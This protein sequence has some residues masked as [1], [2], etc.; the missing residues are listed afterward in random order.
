MTV[1]TRLALL[2]I[3]EDSVEEKDRLR[4]T[5][6]AVLNILEDLDLE[7]AK[8]EDANT[9]L[10]AE[11]AERSRAEQALQSRTDDLA[12]SNADLEQ[13]AYVASHD[14]SEPLRAISGPISLLARRYQGQLD[15]EADEY[16]GFVVDGCQRMQAIIDGLLAYSRVGRFEADG[17]V[18]R[19]QHVA[20]RRSLAWLAPT[21]DATD[22]E[23]SVGELPMVFAEKTQL[24]EVFLNLISN[25]LKFVAPD[26]SLAS[27]SG[28]TSRRARGVSV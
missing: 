23:V 16:I 17:G 19:L 10:R 12:N 13:F 14:L 25:A 21:I 1:T 22:A 2:N 7:K 15:A 9:E 28:R 20:R 8:I 6:R 4:D 11:V 3:L 27:P 26:G 24:S 5:Q 18:G